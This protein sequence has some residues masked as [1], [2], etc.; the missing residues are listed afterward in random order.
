MKI[1]RFE[2]KNRV[3]AYQKTHPS[4]IVLAMGYFDGVHR[5]HQ[6]VI[7]Q[8]KRLAEE[9][10]LACALMSFDRQ[11]A[12]LFRP[13]DASLETY[14]SPAERKSQLLAELGVDIFFLVHFTPAFAQ[15]APQAF[16]DRYI[17]GLNV[18]T[19]VAGE[20]YTYGPKDVA[21]MA[22]LPQ[23][24]KER[25][26]IVQVPEVYDQ[27]G[28]ISSSS[29]RLAI[30]EGQMEKAR[31][32]LGYPYTISGQV[33]TGAQRGRKIGYP[34]ANI[35]VKAPYLLP[36]PGVYVAQVPYGG[37]T[38]PAFLQLGYNKTF[39]KDR[40]DLSLE[41]HLFNFSGDLYG[42]ELSVTFLHFLREEIR[43]PSAEA[44]IQQLAQ[45]KEA[46]FA[47]LRELDEGSLS[48]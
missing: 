20:D 1:V 42:Q 31:A 45:D 18:D 7:R 11:P 35:A 37:T 5:G 12:S 17:V 22:N 23:F 46:S 27:G 40:K 39:E 26:E 30:K 21:N 48:R 8:A 41:V 34:T 38:Y 4:P 24:A 32:D 33:V 3:D 13:N 28:K 6:A 44:L 10:G 19:L 15:Q 47:Y 36:K 43:F 25:F 29:I 14:L 9:K 2:D 16:V